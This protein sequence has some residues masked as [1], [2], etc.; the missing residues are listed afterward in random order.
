MS[1]EI[2]PINT[3]KRSFT[4]FSASNTSLRIHQLTLASLVAAVPIITIILGILGFTPALQTLQSNLFSAIETHLAPGS[5]AIVTPY[6]I[7]FAQQAKKLPLAGSIMLILTALL[8]LNSF[9]SSVQAIWHIEKRRNLRDRLLIYWAIL[10]LGPILL[11]ASWSI[12]GKV[13]S[14]KWQ[15]LEIDSGLN[16]ILD[17]G[18]F[19]LYFALLFIL[20]YLAP[21]IQVKARHALISSLVGTVGILIIN[22]LFSTFTS[23][24]ANYQIVYGAF[25]ALPTLIIWLQL[26]WGAILFSVCFCAVLHSPK[27]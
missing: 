4:L 1:E 26:I 25:A 24:F 6:L 9:E 22:Y 2:T 14:L 23:F 3:I 10:T 27:P 19:A 17:L 7:E 8:L 15:G 11:G 20:N 5:S 13:L 16:S 21:N 12:Y 18:S